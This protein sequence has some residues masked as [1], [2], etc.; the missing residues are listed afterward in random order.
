MH[1]CTGSFQALRSTLLHYIR[2]W[3]LSYYRIA[4]PIVASGG[5]QPTLNRLAGQF[6]N[7]SAAAPGPATD[8]NP[9]NTLPP[10]TSLGSLSTMVVELLLTGQQLF[11]FTA[12]NQY[13]VASSVNG[14]LTAYPHLQELSNIGVRVPLHLYSAVSTS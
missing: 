3:R 6:P 4:G 11:P 12:A 2:D 1:W 10:G 8:S 13:D 9:Y 14:L 5:G 7:V